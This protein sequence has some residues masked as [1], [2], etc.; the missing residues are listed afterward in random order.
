MAEK[1][2]FAIKICSYEGGEG[3]TVIA[4]NLAVALASM[5]KRVL[6]MDV[7]PHS[8]GVADFLGLKDAKV[9]FLD[10]LERGLDV[11]KGIVSYPPGKIDVM[12]DNFSIKYYNPSPR[13]V[14]KTASQIVRLGYDFVISDSESGNMVESA[15][16]YY[17]ELL[18]II[19]PIK[20]S[21]RF[22]SVLIKRYGKL[23]VPYRIVM[24]RIHKSP[25]RADSRTLVEKELGAKIAVSIP[26]DRKVLE[27]VAKAKPLY[28]MDKHSKF[29][30]AIGKLARF[31]IKEAEKKK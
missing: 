19:M 28:L 6:L 23:G 31:Y 17:S 4:I 11:R 8:R 2:P 22:E 7:D 14:D 21:A 26:Y 3:K 10:V 27:S 20:T 1:R 15:I 9:S 25:R 5:G 18:D 29:S 24:N 13:L 12:P 30:Q 16:K